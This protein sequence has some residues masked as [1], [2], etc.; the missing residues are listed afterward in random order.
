MSDIVG[1]NTTTETKPKRKGLWWKILLGVLA[2]FLAIMVLGSTNSPD[3]QVSRVSAF[4]NDKR[5]VHIVNIGQ[6]MLQIKSVV[7]NNRDD[8]VMRAYGTGAAVKARSTPNQWV[9][10]QVGED[11]Y[12]SSRCDV[13]H[14]DID[15]DQGSISYSFDR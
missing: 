1:D 11:V 10:L 6:K 8:C 13:V 2:L 14:V 12:F 7:A 3:L 5:A 9:P 15:T 4:I